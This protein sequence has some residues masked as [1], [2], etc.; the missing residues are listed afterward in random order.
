M[1]VDKIALITDSGADIRPEVA[2]QYPI[3]TVPYTITF[4]DGSYQ[5]GVNIF[6]EDI[7]RK[8]VTEMPKTSLPSG[9]AIADTFQ[10]IKDDGYDKAIAIM[11]SSG[12]SGCYQMTRLM[13]QECEALE[14]AVF[15][16]MSGSL[17]QGTMILTI[18]RW[19]QEGR[20]WKQIIEMIPRMMKNIHPFFSVDTLEYLQRGGRIGKIT[21]F[22]GTAL[23]IKPILA[24]DGT[25]GE[26]TSIH[27]VR[28]RAAA[29]RKLVQTAVSHIN[30]N[31]RYNIMWAH[32]GT[33]EEGEK[34]AE[35][36]RSA[37]PDFI[38]EFS[39]EIDCTLASYVG[40]HLLGAA[41]QVLDDD[42]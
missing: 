40:P 12:L 31:K 22:A 1:S 24:F 4:S 3:Y 19:I 37:A 25:T 35:M 16:S 18:A 29:M 42:M 41:V 13:A 5:D 20:T 7:Y 23:G 17:G 39:G 30:P 2:A 27:K 34:I 38:E 9:A 14:I 15:D 32:G 10:K 26:L 33:P 11:L 28:G 21:A 36:L 8:Q 6:P